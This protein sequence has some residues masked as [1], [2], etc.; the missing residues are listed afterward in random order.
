MAGK[1]RK[2]I[3]TCITCKE[4]KYD[5][6]PAKP[7]IKA[8]P[9]PEFP[10]QIVHIDILHMGKQLILT[11]VDKLSK[12][13]VAKPIKSKAAEDIRQPLRDII[14][15]LIPETVVMDNEK[16][17][18]SETINYMM[19]NEFGIEIHRT[20]PYKSCSNGQVERFH[21][22]LQEVMRCLQCDKTHHSFNELLK[23][24]S[25]GV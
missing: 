10:G 22:T 7:K 3:K 12:Y 6:H 13:A 11:A 9:I 25:Q 15:S 1:I 18:R 8:T 23:K 21:S 20:G 14:F 4:N 24:I 19:E 2:L 5:R 17:F 16:S